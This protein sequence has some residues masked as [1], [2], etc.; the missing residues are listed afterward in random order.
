MAKSPIA[1]LYDHVNSRFLK[2]IQDGYE[3][4]MGV[5]SK[6]RN[7]AGTIV[8]PSTEDTLATRLSQTTGAAIQTVLEAVRDTDGIK[9][10]TDSLPAGDNNIGN[11][12]AIQSGTWTVQQGTP[13]WKME[14]K[15]ADGAPP[16]ENP[17]LVAGQDGTNVQS[18]KTNASGR[19]ENVIHDSSGNAVGVVLDGA[20][21]RLQGD[22][23][24]AKGDLDLVH[25]QVIDVESGLGRMKTT[26]YTPDGDPVAFGAVSSS[27]KNDFVKT[28]GGSSNLLDTWAGSPV[29][30]TYEADD[31][32][33][34]SLQEIRFTMASN[35]ITFGSEYF[36]AVSGPLTNGLL[37][38]AVSN[39]TA[40]TIFNIKQNEEFVLFASPGGWEWVVS[41]KDLMTSAYLIGGGLK[42]YAGTGDMVRVT[43]R[44]DIDSAGNYF[45]CFVKGNLLME[46]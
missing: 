16:T 10:I 6:L 18:F 29:T 34:I 32:Y 26:I 33:D 21:Y 7:A 12:D 28:D 24:V 2:Y 1:I 31:D 41:N 13:P 15:D 46:G 35:S 44:D 43:V 11:V 9:K 42:L 17:I 37:I 25:L 23:K 4:L 20:V 40:V 5:A 8:N 22:S 38:E 45:Q 19:I 39:G 3:S 27:V 36:G 14:G 30:Y